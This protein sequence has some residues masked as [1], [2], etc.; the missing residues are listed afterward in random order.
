MPRRVN[1]G[2]TD[3]DDDDAQQRSVRAT[4]EELELIDRG[5]AEANRG[6]LVDARAFLRAL[7]QRS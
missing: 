3:L 6:E 5:L 4:D 1:N 7:Q 2:S